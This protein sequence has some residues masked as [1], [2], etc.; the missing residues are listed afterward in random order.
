[1]R[2]RLRFRCPEEL[3]EG[4]HQE[5]ELVSAVDRSSPSSI[6]I[7]R[8]GHRTR[9]DPGPRSGAGRTSGQ[10]DSSG[11]PVRVPL[12]E[13]R[14]GQGVGSVLAS[15]LRPGLNTRRSGYIVWVM[16]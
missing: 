8:Y 11:M 4:L 13:T 10:R 9:P 6:K 16:S 12:D 2:L 15:F 5:V 1:M 3:T 14:V 7:H